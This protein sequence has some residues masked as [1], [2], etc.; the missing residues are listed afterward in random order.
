M[1]ELISKSPE[2]KLKRLRSGRMQ[3]PLLAL[4][5]ATLMG[6]AQVSADLPVH[7]AHHKNVGAWEFSMVSRPLSDWSPKHCV[8]IACIM[9]T[10]VQGGPAQDSVV[11]Q[12]AEADTDVLL[13]LLLHQQGETL[14]VGR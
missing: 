11:Q 1:Q 9:F 4:A 8:L 10:T 12:E 3:V 13:R 7:C 14:D 2:S 5:L 6:V